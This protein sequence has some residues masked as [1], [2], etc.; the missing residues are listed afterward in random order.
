MET[1]TSAFLTREGFSTIQ[2][3]HLP[4]FEISAMRDNCHLKVRQSPSAGFETDALSANAPTG[5]RVRYEYDGML[6]D[7]HP[8]FRATVREMWNRTV[9]R[10]HLDNKWTPVLSIIAS[11][12]CDLNLLDWQP[13]ARVRVG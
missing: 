13:L 9:W 4:L 1:V 7:T 6:W 10:L 8:S 11:G 3:E 2:V 5:S 12:T